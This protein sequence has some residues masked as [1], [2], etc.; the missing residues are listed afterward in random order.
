MITPVV[1]R[2]HTRIQPS[3]KKSRSDRHSH[4]VPISFRRSSPWRINTL[5]L[6]FDQNQ[7][8]PTLDLEATL[9]INGVDPHFWW[10]FR[11]D[12]PF[13]SYGWNVG[14]TF[15]YPSKTARRRDVCSSHNWLSVSRC[16]ASR[17]WRRASWLKCA[18]LSVMCS[19]LPTCTGDTDL[20]A[21]CDQ[22]TRGRREKT[23]GWAGDVFTTLQFQDVLSC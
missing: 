3:T 10:E 15:R 12:R 23:P 5:P 17:I 9:R 7:T 22:T 8:L 2:Q 19:R 4:S 6:V 1:I 16:Y 18:T 14:L 21:T 11:P 20:G 13:P